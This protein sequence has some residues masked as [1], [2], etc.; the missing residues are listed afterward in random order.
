MRG[1][2]TRTCSPIRLIFIDSEA[3]VFKTEW[4][5]LAGELLGSAASQFS[6]HGC[7]DWAWP[8][9]WTKAQR[10]ELAIAMV[11]QNTGRNVGEFTESDREQIDAMCAGDYGPPDW[12]VMSFLGDVLKQ[13]P[14]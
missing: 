7:N 5:T 6:S 10:L 13:P 1:S 2:G 12:W 11:A 14:P 3:S 8:K 4:L 9:N